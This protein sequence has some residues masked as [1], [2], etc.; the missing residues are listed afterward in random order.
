V[1]P[2]YRKIF[3]NWKHLWAVCSVCAMHIF[4]RTPLLNIGYTAVVAT[5]RVW[6]HTG[7]V[8]VVATHVWIRTG[9][10]AAVVATHVWI[11]TGPVGTEAAIW[12]EEKD[13]DVRKLYTS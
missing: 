13:P 8:G 5:A 2:Y 1:A 6:I 12:M 4:Y 11:R 7:R 3:E 10:V 9:L